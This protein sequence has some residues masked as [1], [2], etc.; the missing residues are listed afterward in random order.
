MKEPR[1]PP[2]DF[3]E[4]SASEGEVASIP[5]AGPQEHGRRPVEHFWPQDLSGR[6]STGYPRQEMSI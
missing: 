1:Q 4:V 3:A 5:E 2:W 6:Y